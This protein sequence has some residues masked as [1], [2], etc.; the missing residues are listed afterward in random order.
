MTG[1]K[2]MINSDFNGKK[3]EGLWN[4]GSITSFVNSNFIKTKFN[5][6]KTEYVK[7][8]FGENTSNLTLGAANNSKL[9]IVGVV[10]FEFEIIGFKINLVY[11]SS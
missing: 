11:H 8:F 1:H 5:Y 2:P 3:F 6:I 9:E 7:K 4:T 10:T